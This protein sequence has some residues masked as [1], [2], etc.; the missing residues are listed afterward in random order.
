MTSFYDALSPHGEWFDLPPYGMQDYDPFRGYLHSDTL[1][2]SYGAMRGRSGDWARQVV[3]LPTAKM[4]DAVTAVGF[5]GLWIDRRGYPNAAADVEEKVAALTGK[6]PV[7]SSDGRFWFSDLRDH[8]RAVEQRLGTEG[9]AQ[10]RL[11]Q[12]DSRGEDVIG[13][14]RDRRTSGQCRYGYGDQLH[15][16]ALGAGADVSARRRPQHALGHRAI[17]Q[18]NAEQQNARDRQGAAT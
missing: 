2:W 9:V 15:H 18:R 7:L 17:G 3:K 12:L 13:H 11:Q 4:L 10:L 6:E 8:S 16:R 5:R 1:R 14:A